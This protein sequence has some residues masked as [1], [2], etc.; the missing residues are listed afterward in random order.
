[1]KRKLIK[2][3]EQYKELDIEI[4]ALKLRIEAETIKGI[5]YNDMPSSPNSNTRSSVEDAVLLIEKLK[6]DIARLEI[7]KRSIENL[8]ELLSDRDRIMF[9]MYYIEDKTLY[10]IAVKLDL[11]YQ[12]VY[13]VKSKMINNLLKYAERF[14]VI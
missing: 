3:F 4:N 9:N 2:E 13:Q 14:G 1:M 12:Y 11:S 6:K 10:D 7:K 5:S 8:L